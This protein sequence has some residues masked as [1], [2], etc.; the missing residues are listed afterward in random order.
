MTQTKKAW[1]PEGWENPALDGRIINEPHHNWQEWS[2]GWEAGADAM[3]EKLR[4]TAYAEIKNSYDPLYFFSVDETDTLSKGH[5]VFI[6]E[7]E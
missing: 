4:K 3:L 6:P 7:D 5:L 2:N 1:R